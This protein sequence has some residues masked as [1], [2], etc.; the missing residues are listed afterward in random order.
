MPPATRGTTDTSWTTATTTP[1]E[2]IPAKPEGIPVP[3]WPADSPTSADS[4]YV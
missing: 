1:S 4:M 3:P 2:A